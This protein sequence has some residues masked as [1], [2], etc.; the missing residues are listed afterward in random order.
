MELIPSALRS[1]AYVA[2]SVS[3]ARSVAYHIA[4]FAD[5][6][7]YN[8]TLSIPSDEIVIKIIRHNNGK[9]A[10]HVRILI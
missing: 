2:V 7:L 5:C 1:R 3:I 10:T 8:E 9:L 6:G 4:L